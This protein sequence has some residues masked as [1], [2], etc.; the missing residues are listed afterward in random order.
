MQRR[1]TL[2]FSLRSICILLTITAIALGVAAEWHRY[3]NS[4]SIQ[5]AVEEYNQQ[6]DDPRL[7]LT[8]KQAVDSLR[9]W[10]HQTAINIRHR[11]KFRAILSAR[12][13]PNNLKFTALSSVVNGQHVLSI[14]TFIIDEQGYTIRTIDNGTWPE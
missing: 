14:C 3:H 5:T 9:N 6:N 10:Q 2:R 11:N 13:V 12:R 8:V 7:R 4:R 1:P